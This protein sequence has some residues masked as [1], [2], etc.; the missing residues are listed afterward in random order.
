MFGKFLLILCPQT[1]EFSYKVKKWAIPL[2]LPYPSIMRGLDTLRAECGHTVTSSI[3]TSTLAS[4]G[5]TL[6]ILFFIL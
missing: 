4:L 6:R 1:V 3:R 2:Q 5:Q